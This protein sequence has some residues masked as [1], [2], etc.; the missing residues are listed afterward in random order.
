MSYIIYKYQNKICQ[1]TQPNVNGQPSVEE[2]EAEIE[3]LKD[4]DTEDT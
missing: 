4:M 3:N 2:I 1:K